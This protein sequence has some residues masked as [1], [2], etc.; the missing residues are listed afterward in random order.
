M[1]PSVSATALGYLMGKVNEDICLRTGGL[2]E[3][4]M[5]GGRDNLLVSLRAFM[6]SVTMD[7]AVLLVCVV[8][9]DG[10]HLLWAVFVWIW[11]ILMNGLLVEWLVW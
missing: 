10:I 4:Y 2:S 8:V 7:G 5:G 6:F 3:I 9:G 1:M 11:V